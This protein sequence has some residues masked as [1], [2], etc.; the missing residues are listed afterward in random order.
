LIVPA[1]LALGGYLFNR[2]ER[3]RTQYDADLHR[4]QERKL[5][6]EG[7]QTDMLQAYYEQI[8]KLPS[9]RDLRNTATVKK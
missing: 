5:A 9:E 1:V 8:G 6:N 7:R 2:A 3:Q 4:A